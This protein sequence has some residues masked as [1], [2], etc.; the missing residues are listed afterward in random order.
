[1]DDLR[2]MLPLSVSVGGL[3]ATTLRMGRV[4]MTDMDEGLTLNNAK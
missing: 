3:L 4:D 2:L 1:M